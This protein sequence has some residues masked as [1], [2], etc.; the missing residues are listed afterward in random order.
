MSRRDIGRAILW[1][2]VAFMWRLILCKTDVELVTGISGLKSSLPCNITPKFEDDSPALVLWYKDKSPTPIYTLDARK[3]PFDQA[4]HSSVDSIAS[5]AYVTMTSNLPGSLELDPV[6]EVDEG[7]YRCR[8]DFRRER[9]RYTDSK[10]KVIVLPGKPIIS[11]DNGHV[12][13][14]LIGPYNEGDAL[15]LRCETEGGSP[16]PSLT[17]W[18]ESV[19]LDDTYMQVTSDRK[20]INELNIG[21]LQRHD[22]M[23]ALS[24]QANN[25]NISQ[26]LISTVTVDMNFRP[27][28]VEVLADRQAFSAG[29]VV[30][31]ICRAI[32][33]RPAAV[34]SWWAGK[35]QLKNSK[36]SV[37][38][39]G[40][41]TTSYLTFRPTSEDDGKTVH[42]RAENPFIADSTVQ[43]EKTLTVHYVPKVSVHIPRHLTDAVVKRGHDIF[44]ECHVIAK[45]PVSE[46]VWMFEDIELHT[47]KSEGIIV[48]NH[49]LALQGVDRT[50]KGHYTCVATNAEGKGSSEPVL[51]RIQF[52]P[53]CK[54]NQQ[55]VYGA[56]LN[57]PIN[58]H[59][60]VEAEPPE[61]TFHWSFNDSK[62]VVDSLTFESNLTKSVAV[63]TPRK[64]YHYGILLCW[65]RNEIG[66]Q[67]D[68]CAYK[69]IPTG[70]PQKPLSC[71][72]N[73]RTSVA[74]EVVCLEGYSDGFNQR[75]VFEVY[76]VAMKKLVTNFTASHPMF[77]VHGLSPGTQF[78]ITVYSF[79]H[80]GRSET[81]T[82]KISTLF[83]SSHEI[84]APETDWS[85][86]FKPVLVLLCAVSGGLVLVILI[87]LLG[88]KFRRKQKAKRKSAATNNGE[89]NREESLTLKAS[90]E[91]YAPLSMLDDER[92]P[93]L[94]PEIRS[95]LDGDLIF[96]C[97]SVRWPSTPKNA[98]QVQNIPMSSPRGS[99][100]VATVHGLSQESGLRVKVLRS[101]P[102]LRR[103]IS[104]E[105]M[106]LAEERNT[107]V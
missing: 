87:I 44:L 82:T 75:F 23:A 33:S 16:S 3:I 52:P 14:S 104:G 37:S 97:D 6:T 102:V 51:L 5:R 53:V 15:V 13:R 64:H 107:E 32:G 40:N 98:G 56:S 38:V 58:I 83:N 91:G 9:T 81:W 49:S 11:N 7:A 66:S 73:N 41:V 26:P 1:L 100:Q 92:C 69:V 31:L 54:P 65:G 28:V 22:L 46:I 101:S 63:F 12:L 74:L 106:E 86:A 61:V 76:N 103:N 20:V 94:I 2:V 57:E 17:W 35:T 10:L 78:L 70:T 105:I 84:S 72:I 19:L 36:S 88:V 29:H 79:N 39:D 77:S 99:E 55:V 21:S 59:C 43:E 48:T 71:T 95:T 50:K 47:N 8:V 90:G 62:D 67:T 80:K 24:C 60:N 89:E 4:R 68:P 85:G 42:C 93:D 45:P 27:L 34:I 25:N 30:Q 96:H 18:R